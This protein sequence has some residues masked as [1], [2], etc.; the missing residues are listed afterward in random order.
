L[1]SIVGEYPCA[2]LPDEIEAGHLRAMVFFGGNI[3]ALPE[4]KRTV[5]ALKKLDVLLTFDVRPTETTDISTHV[6]PAKDQLER[7][8]MTYVTE[9]F[10]PYLLAQYTPPMVEPVGERKSVW[11]V[12]GELGKRMGVDFFPGFETTHA[13]DDD[14]LAYIAGQGRSGYS[15]DDIKA[16]RVITEPAPIGWVTK[17]VDEKIGGWRLAPELVVEQIGKLEDTAPLV[18]IPRRQKH[19]E[20]SKFLDHAD[21][22]DKPCIFVSPADAA[23]HGL[24]DGATI[25]VRSKNG[26]LKGVMKI[27][28]T[29]RPGAM[30]VPHGW[31]GQYNVN[32]LTGTKHYVDPITGMVRFSGLPVSLHAV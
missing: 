19:H 12:L 17:F 2:A 22:R 31:S 13:T 32:N 25:E 4:V 30:T 8:D 20:N 27:D 29:L 9:F 23:S 7:A 11:W 3:P 18:L 26:S 6:A 1:P 14:M 16:R 28:P 21:Q 15:F 10:Y 24:K 5:E